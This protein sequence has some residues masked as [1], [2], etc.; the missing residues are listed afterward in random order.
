VQILVDQSVTWGRANVTKRWVGEVPGQTN[1][2]TPG[3]VVLNEWE[4]LPWGS[5]SERGGI[6]TWERKMLWE[7]EPGCYLLTFTVTKK[8]A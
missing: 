6:Y 4:R 7:W 3:F 2:S 1:G 8:G 5:G